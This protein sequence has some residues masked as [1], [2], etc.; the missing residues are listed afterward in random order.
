MKLR[1]EELT[2]IF[3][4]IVLKEFGE[5]QKENPFGKLEKYK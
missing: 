4:A 3:S 2:D 1:K 5:E